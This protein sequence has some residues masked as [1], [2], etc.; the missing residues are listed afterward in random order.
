MSLLLLWHPTAVQCAEPAR[1]PPLKLALFDDL[2]PQGNLSAAEDALSVLISTVGEESR[3]PVEFDLL[4]GGTQAEFKDAVRKIQGGEYHLLVVTGLEYGWWL[5]L[6]FDQREILVQCDPG[7]AAIRQF[8]ELIVRKDSAFRTPRELKDA[9]LASYQ[10]VSTAY[11]IY[12]ERL[13]TEFPGIFSPQSQS[14]PH[15]F[16]AMHAVN[17]GKADAAIIDVYARSR[18]AM[19]FEKQFGNLKVIHSSIKYPPPVIAG[20]R[21]LI[22]QLDPGLWNR[23]KSALKQIHNRRITENF[24][25]VWSMARFVDADREYLKRAAAAAADY[26][27]AELAPR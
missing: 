14:V 25:N 5:G 12:L 27:F 11:P 10:R 23:L 1:R 9:R 8:Q 6:P 18:F 7:G 24:L 22:E 4:P 16:A 19:A 13:Q 21:A 20:N 26:R 17:Q 3:Y 15:S 2:V